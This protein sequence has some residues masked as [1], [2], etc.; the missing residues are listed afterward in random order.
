[1]R[2]GMRKCLGKGGRGREGGREGGELFAIN[3][4]DWLGQFLVTI[5]TIFSSTTLYTGFSN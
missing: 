2:E 1:V 5:H 3:S 4:L